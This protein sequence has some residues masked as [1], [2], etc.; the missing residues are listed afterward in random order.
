MKSLFILGNGFDLAHELPTKYKDFHKY[1]KT[2]YPKALKINPSFNIESTIMPDG[3][4]VFDKDEV[5][6]FIMDVISMTEGEGN[7]WRNIENSL[8]KLDFNKYFDDLSLLFDED[9]DKELFRMAYRH[10]DISSN[11]RKVILNIKNLFS[12]WVNTIDINNSCSIPA[13]EKL[14]NEGNSIFLTFNYTTVLEY[15]YNIDDPFHIHGVQHSDIIIGH[16]ETLDEDEGYRYIGSEYELMAIH[17]QLRKDTDKIITQSKEFFEGVSDIDKI[18][19]H[20]FS[21]SNVDLP[22]IKEICSK[23]NTTNVTWYLNDDYDNETIRDNFLSI[24]KQCGF[25]G[26][27]DVYS[28]KDSLII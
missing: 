22:Y 5:V 27:F 4:E 18:Y 8:G 9:D 10:E 6:A 23:Q 19:S 12:D 16:G 3:E 21:F 20:G 14:F 13:F 26:N 28:I 25:E 15:L 7:D 2:N 1:L 11:F 17:T 24:I